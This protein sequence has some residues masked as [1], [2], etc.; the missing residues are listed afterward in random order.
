MPE[1][2]KLD[3]HV[4]NLKALVRNCEADGV[5]AYDHLIQ[6]IA[7]VF[8]TLRDDAMAI[9]NFAEQLMAETWNEIAGQTGGGTTN[10]SGGTTIPGTDPNAGPDTGQQPV[11]GGTDPATGEPI[12]AVD[13]VRPPPAVDTGNTDEVQVGADPAGSG[14]FSAKKGKAA[15]GKNLP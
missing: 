12:P 2:P 14:N 10:T 15:Q 5:R 13:P 3:H 7:G 4:P 8:N 9:K 11:P 6:A 1:T